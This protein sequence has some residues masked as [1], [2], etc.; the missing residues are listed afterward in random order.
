MLNKIVKYVY[1][2][3]ILASVVLAGIF[4]LKQ[5]PE[6]QAQLDAA[7]KLSSELKVAEVES[8]ANNWGGTVLNW[9]VILFIVVGAITVLYGIY[10]FV[11][12][13]IESKQGMIRNLVSVAVVAVVILGGFILASNVIPAMNVDKLDFEVTAKMSKNIG[14]VLYMTYLF[15]GLAIVGV[16]YM[17]VSKLWK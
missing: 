1:W 12:S 14:S 10:R 15:L 16:V 6:L 3:L 13:M 11:M 2:A 7:S 8:I 4:F 5:A 17:E 9:G